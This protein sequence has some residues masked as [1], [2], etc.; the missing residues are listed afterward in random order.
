[1]RCYIEA[2]T[3]PRH[4]ARSRRARHDNVCVRVC[5]C[6]LD[7]SHV[8]GL[9]PSLLP[10]GYRNQLEYPDKLPELGGGELERGILAL[11]EY[12]TE[13]STARQGWVYTK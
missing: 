4:V 12:L 9:F 6:A 5:V 11:I 13:V 8:V 1:M 3:E 10:Q 2:I 7:P